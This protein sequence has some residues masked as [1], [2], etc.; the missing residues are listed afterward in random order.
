ME[1]TRGNTV[2]KI[3]PVTGMSCASCAISVESM[4][5]TQKGVKQAAV[6]FAAQNVQVEYDPSQIGLPEMK[7]VIQSIGYD[8]MIDEQN[9]ASQQQ[10]EQ[11]K[12]Y[13]RILVDV[14]NT[15]M[16]AYCKEI[17][18]NHKVICTSRR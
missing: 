17:H 2:K 3:L 12:A 15:N 8:L 11:H 6:N 16:R 10:D 9:A 1:T 14:N 18:N 13:K 7:K 4:I 5:Q